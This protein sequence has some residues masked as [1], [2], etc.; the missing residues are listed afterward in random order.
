MSA[1]IVSSYIGSSTKFQDVFNLFKNRKMLANNEAGRLSA[2]NETPGF[3][4]YLFNPLFQLTPNS[5]SAAFSPIDEATSY[6]YSAT[7]LFAP[8]P[9]LTGDLQIIDSIDFEENTYTVGTIPDLQP[10][11]EY[12]IFLTANDQSISTSETVSQYTAFNLDVASCSNTSISLT[13]SPLLGQ[14]SL[15]AYVYLYFLEGSSIYDD[16]FIGSG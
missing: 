11:S 13:W 12:E 16:E 2:R 15:I 9:T 10:G 1:S 14:T 7:P 4:L 6:T 3:N 8:I 5:V